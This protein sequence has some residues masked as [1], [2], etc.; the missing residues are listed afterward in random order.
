MNT[1]PT[2]PCEPC[3]LDSSVQLVIPTPP[4]KSQEKLKKKQKKRKAEKPEPDQSYNQPRI[5]LPTKIFNTLKYVTQRLPKT[6]NLLE[7][8]MKPYQQPLPQ[9]VY[10]EVDRQARSLLLAMGTLMEMTYPADKVDFL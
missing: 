10:R 9:M 5:P 4:L 2:S 1:P 6:M 3:Q 7:E 8:A